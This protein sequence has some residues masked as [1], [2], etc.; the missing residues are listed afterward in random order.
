MSEN[1]IF[2][3]TRQA[4]LAF[5]YGQADTSFYTKQVLDAV[6]TGRGAV[7]REL[8]NLTDAGIIIREVQGRQVY[9]RANKKCPI[10]SDLKSILRKTSGVA[11]IV[12]EPFDLVAQRFSIP[13]N[14]LEEYC[15]RHHI[16]KLALFGSVLRN[17]FHPG[18][19]VDVLVEFEPGHVPG[20]AIIDMESE[21]S[22]LIEHKVDLRT[23]GD[24]SRY[25]RDRVIRE[26]RLQ[27]VET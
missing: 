2:G 25:F 14:R 7:Q 10:F 8:K 9:Y 26:A 22:Q 24:L 21:L 5:L 4:V 19:D 11:D 1:G 6:K 3:K 16:K 17:D 12:S 13:K 18:S 15:R 23:P 27:Y 20:F